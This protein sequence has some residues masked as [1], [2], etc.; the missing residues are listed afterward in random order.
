VLHCR[1]QC[2]GVSFTDDDA[3]RALHDELLLCHVL[4]LFDPS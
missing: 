1:N 2:S 4:L 3:A